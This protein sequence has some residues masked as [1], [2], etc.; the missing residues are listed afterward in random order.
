MFGETH[1]KLGKLVIVRHGQAESNKEGFFAGWYDSDLTEKGVNDA[2]FAANLIKNENIDFDISY[3]SFLK[4]S[5][6]T[7][8]IILDQLNLLHIPTVSTWRLNECHCGE[9]TCMKFND[10]GKFGNV[11][12]Q[13]WREEFSFQ[14]PLLQQNDTRSPLFDAHYKGIDTRLLPLGES[15]EQAWERLKPFWYDEILRKVYQNKNVLVVSHGNLIRAMIMS[16]EKKDMMKKRVVPN[17]YPIVYTFQDGK[18]KDKTILGQ[19]NERIE[20]AIHA[21]II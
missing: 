20:A 15:L 18:L 19:K 5:I 9:Y 2:V 11:V 3:S 1:E 13:R 21:Q 16:I 10:I 7:Q 4:R 17:G 8:L 12:Y 14:P 6:R